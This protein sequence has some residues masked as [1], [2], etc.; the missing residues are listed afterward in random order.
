MLPCAITPNVVICPYAMGCNAQRCP[1]TAAGPAA[2]RLWH[3]VAVYQA[4]T[5]HDA[6]AVACGSLLAQE[7]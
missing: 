4:L 3:L 5:P 1:Q 7:H 2:K 6:W